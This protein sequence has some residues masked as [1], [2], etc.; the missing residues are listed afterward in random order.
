MKSIKE[1]INNDSSACTR[2]SN[3]DTIYTIID[4]ELN[5]VIAVLAYP[6]DNKL[7]YSEMIRD[8]FEFSCRVRIG[9]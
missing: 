3:K 2:M 7:L 4:N 1:I 6:H 8:D 5:E 9:V